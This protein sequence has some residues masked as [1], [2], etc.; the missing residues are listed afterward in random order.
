VAKE[1]DL[2]ETF[3]G[4]EAALAL[5]ANPHDFLID[6]KA[7]FAGL[8]YGTLPGS[9]TEGLL[10]QMKALRQP[11]PE[12]LA[13]HDLFMVTRDPAY[14]LDVQVLLDK[15]QFPGVLPIRLAVGEGGPDTGVRFLR[16][17]ENKLTGTVLD[18]NATL[19]FTGPLQG[20]DIYVATVPGGLGT[21]PAQTILMHVNANDAPTE[22]ENG[23]I[24]T[25][26]ANAFAAA[27]GGSA[28]THHLARADYAPASGDAYN[29]FVYGKKRDD[30]SWDF[31][32]Y[33]LILGARATTHRLDPLP[34]A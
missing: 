11:A 20:C 21:G 4:P 1:P 22:A 32:V 30:G 33:T 27:M 9:S 6:T 19:V 26:K 10:F 17:Q 24:K 18:A 16:W 25:E 5:K 29:G 3:D 15:P 13:T 34:P 12:K 23:P 2:T 7:S 14:G 8:N 31:F 28:I